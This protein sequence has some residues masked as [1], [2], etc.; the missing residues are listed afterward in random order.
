MTANVYGH[1]WGSCAWRCGGCLTVPLVEKVVVP[2]YAVT[3]LLRTDTR[4]YSY[5]VE[6][7]WLKHDWSMTMEMQLVPLVSTQVLYLEQLLRMVFILP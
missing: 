3:V 5:I 6:F 2:L 1:S 7:S 4:L